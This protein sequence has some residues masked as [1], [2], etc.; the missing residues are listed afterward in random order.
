MPHTIFSPASA[1]LRVPLFQ[2]LRSAGGRV[3]RLDIESLPEHLKRDL[4][5]SG[6][7]ASPRRDPMRD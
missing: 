1:A 3:P 2:R 7:R 6:G 5:I 4:G